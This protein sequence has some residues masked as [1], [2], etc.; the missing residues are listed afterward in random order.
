MGSW[1]SLLSWETATKQ[2]IEVEKNQKEE[3][4]TLFR[5]FRFNPGGQTRFKELTKWDTKESINNLSWR[6]LL[7]LGGIG[8]GKT[9]VGAAWAISRCIQDSQARGAIVANTFGQLSRSTILGLVEVC[10]KY[11]VPLEPYADS[12]E[13]QALRIVNSQRCYIGKDRAFVFVLSMGSFTGTTQAARGLQI[14]WYW[15]DELA[16]SPE[17]AFLT[18]DGRLGRGVGSM[19]GQ[20]VITTSPNSFNWLFDKFA[21]PNRDAR[22]TQL[23]QLIKVSSRENV[24]H[25]GEDYLSSLEANYTDELAR[26]E[27]LGDFVNSAVGLVYKYFDRRVHCLRD[28]DAE[29]LEYDPNLPLMLSF[30]FNYSPAIC[31]AAQ[32]RQN[33]IHFFKEWF[34]LDSDLWEL[35]ESVTDWIIENG[36][37]A[38]LLI[39]GDATGHARSANSRLSSWDIVTEQLKPITKYKPQGYL[40][41]KFAKSNPH[42]INRIHSVN[43][44]FKQNRCFLD[45]VECPNLIKDFEQVTYTPDKAIAKENALLSHLSDAAGYLIHSLYP[46]KREGHREKLGTKKPAGVAS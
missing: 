44:L 14:R 45:F 11:N 30:D 24:I 5:D 34:I 25:L 16:Y 41:K 38:S 18:L 6:H 20:G 39:F 33:E 12:A 19:Q 31:V 21:D 1:N 8:S 10:R 15:G 4:I 22:T 26:Q 2:Q 27:L 3:E 46:F 40:I 13:D 9:T 37:P 35:T 42:V 23:Y 32:Q 43:L 17:S 29:I 28:D 7:L 36:D